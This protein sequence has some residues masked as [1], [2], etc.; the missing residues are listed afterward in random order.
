[1]QLRQRYDAALIGGGLAGLS[2]A[3]LLAKAGHSVVLFEKGTYPAHKVC[4]EYVSFESWSFLQHLGLPLQDMAL[5]QIDRFRLTAPDGRAFDTRLPL[6]GFGISRFKLDAALADCARASG[7]TVVEEAKVEAVSGIAPFRL[8]V[9]IRGGG[10]HVVE[11]ST[12]CGSWGK[13]SNLDRQ[14]KRRFLLQKDRRLNNFIGVKYQLESSWSDN[15]IGLHNFPGGYCGI[16]QVEEGRTSL[17]YLVR[18]EA[19][20]ACGGKLER[21]E[22]EGV[23]MG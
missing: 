10:A 22:K 9:E 7:V 6:G 18:A 3:I 20:R 4:G 17:C 11:A 21:L 5:P 12:C 8:T 13:R 1:M 19:L 16:S 15:C 2:A 23:G 14:W